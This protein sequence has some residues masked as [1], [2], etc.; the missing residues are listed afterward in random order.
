MKLIK[1]HGEELWH[2]EA[3]DNVSERGVRGRG[4]KARVHKA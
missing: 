3:L 1:E 2:T 4:T